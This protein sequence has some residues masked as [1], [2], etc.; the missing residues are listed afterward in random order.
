M[1]RRKKQMI[2][3]S[4]YGYFIDTEETNVI[5]IYPD[6]LKLMRQKYNIP[7]SFNPKLNKYQ[8][9]YQYKFN[10]YRSNNNVDI[11]T[12]IHEYENLAFYN[13]NIFSYNFIYYF[14]SYSISISILISIFISI[15]I[16]LLITSFITLCK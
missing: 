6:N 2:S 14:F 4:D 9:Q 16:Y 10:N 1:I 12:T 15:L 8:Y 11:M 7:T 3:F 5:S 13:Y